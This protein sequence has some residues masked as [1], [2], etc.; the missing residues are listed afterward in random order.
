MNKYLSLAL[1]LLVPLL[2]I[3]GIAFAIYGT[4]GPPDDAR[5]NAAVARLGTVYGIYALVVFVLWWRRR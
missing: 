2:V 5:T 3:F 4:E 1:L